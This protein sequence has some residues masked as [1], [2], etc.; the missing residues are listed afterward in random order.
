MFFIFWL[1]ETQR[2][3]LKRR[4]RLLAEIM[5]KYTMKARAFNRIRLFN[6]NMVYI[7][8]VAGRHYKDKKMIFEG[9]ARLREFR[10]LYALRKRFHR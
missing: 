8:K 4:R 3:T 7:N 9:F 6:Y 2:N 1:H 10:R 5:C